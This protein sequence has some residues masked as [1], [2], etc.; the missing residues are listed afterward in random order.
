MLKDVP[1][2]EIMA[3]P[4]VTIHV[5]DPFHIVEQKFRMKG[6]RHL[7]VLDDHGKVVGLVTQ[8]DLYRTVSPHKTES[9]ADYDEETLDEFILE[10]V[11]KKEPLVLRPD[12]K[13]SDAIE[14]MA[15]RKFGCIP[16]VDDAGRS[17][18]ILTE[19]DILKWI[20]RLFSEA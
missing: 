5:Q 2:R 9:G 7:P 20:H 17:V 6:I 16:I 1:I 8:R 14:I 19:T 12:D 18:G 15:R 13:I 10:Y 4:A 3:S 11:M